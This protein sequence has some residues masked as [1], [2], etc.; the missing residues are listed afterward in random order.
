MSLGA[1]V[2]G[3]YQTC[4]GESQEDSGGALTAFQNQKKKFQ[5]TRKEAADGLINISPA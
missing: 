5:A 1:A 3:L 4:S 2:Q